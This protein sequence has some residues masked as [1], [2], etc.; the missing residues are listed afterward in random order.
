MDNKTKYLELLKKNE[1]K[2]TSQRIILS[3]ILFSGR[4]MHFSAED[5]RKVVLKKGF[6]MSLATIYNNLQTFADFGM[7]KQRRIT[8]KKT[9]F[10]TNISDHYH[11]Y[12]QK[13]GSLTDIPSALV[14]FTKLPKLPK[15]KIIKNLD[16]VINIVDK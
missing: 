3:K 7:I 2:P 6:K 8:K 15:N 13:T 1:L 9:Y 14:K 5:I 11:F 12:D 16:L 4:D 10:D